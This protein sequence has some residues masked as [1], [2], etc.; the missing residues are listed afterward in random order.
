MKPTRN[1]N[2]L[3]ASLTFYTVSANDDVL[4]KNDVCL[5]DMEASGDPTKFN[6]DPM[7]S[8]LKFKNGK[9]VDDIPCP[10]NCPLTDDRC[11]GCYFP[12]NQKKVNSWFKTNVKQWRK[13]VDKTIERKTT[14]DR[15]VCCC[16]G[17]FAKNNTGEGFTNH[18]LRA[19]KTVE[20]I[21]LE[22]E[23]GNWLKKDINHPLF[24]QCWPKYCHN[25]DKSLEKFIKLNATRPC[26]MDD[27]SD[28]KPV[29]WTAGTITGIVVIVIIVL[30]VLFFVGYYFI[31]GRKDSEQPA[32]GIHE[33][34][35][36]M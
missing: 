13:Y 36:L 30:A 23:D 28:N 31:N 3:L 15:L 14:K 9:T 8:E 6:R 1:S 2:L 33:D 4:K 25:R 26:D 5:Y 10:E 32:T 29:E 35:T 19:E 17:C 34:E 24:V 11:Y 22:C 12:K 16:E 21:H 27:W 18:C 7:F 20:E